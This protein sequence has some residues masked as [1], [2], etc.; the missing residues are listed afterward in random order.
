MSNE[1]LGKIAYEAY[2][3]DCRKG[4]AMSTVRWE[5]QGAILQQHWI[6]AAMAVLQTS[7]EYASLL[8][9]VADRHDA[10]TTPIQGGGHAICF[11]GAIPLEEVE[12]R[13]Q[14]IREETQKLF[15]EHS[16]NEGYTK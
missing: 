6:A 11:T 13:S 4:T 10:H 14:R 2:M 12:R 7:N 3:R 5:D 15:S 9:T 1:E 8:A 16:L